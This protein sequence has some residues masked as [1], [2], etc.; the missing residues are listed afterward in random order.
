V[1]LIEDF[2]IFGVTCNVSCPRAVNFK[3]KLTL[4]FDENVHQLKESILRCFSRERHR[5]RSHFDGILSSLFLKRTDVESF[6]WV[7]ERFRTFL[8]IY[9]RVLFGFFIIDFHWVTFSFFIW[10]RRFQ[11]KTSLTKDLL[12]FILSN[13][14][15]NF[16]F[17]FKLGIVALN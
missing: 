17:T 6:Y 15:K 9:E 2:A 5:R 4:N 13:K 14:N 8:F 7:V 16:E 3:L 10:P 1:Q 11:E 12:S